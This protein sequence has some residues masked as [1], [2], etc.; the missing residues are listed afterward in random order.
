MSI[1]N[2]SSS[3]YIIEFNRDT[4]FGVIE[5]DVTKR[6]LSIHKNSFKR[7]SKRYLQDDNQYVGE[8]FDF[9]VIVKSKDSSDTF[10]AINVRHRVLR[11]N[12]EGCS[13]VKAFTHAKALE[14]HILLRHTQK[15]KK[16]KS[17]QSSVV[18]T[19][20]PKKERP[21]PVLISLAPYTTETTSII[22]RF[23][24]KQGVNLK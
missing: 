17:P 5:E 6:L 7:R 8:L 24:G 20:K 10:E 16:E 11:C 2:G 13:R 3:G 14:E 12:V 18:A 21:K 4:G 23:F 1:T 19:Q 15:E 22:G 9:D